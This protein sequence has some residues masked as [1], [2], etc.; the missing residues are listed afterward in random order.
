MTS[1]SEKFREFCNKLLVA[2]DRP[3]VSDQTNVFPIMELKIKLT[4]NGLN[5]TE[6]CVCGYVNL[7]NNRYWPTNEPNI[8]HEVP[9][10]DSKTG[11]WCAISRRGIIGPIFFKV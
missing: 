6:P 3:S 7:Q 4:Q 11:V 1:R 10:H 5:K 9:L 2:S 8:I